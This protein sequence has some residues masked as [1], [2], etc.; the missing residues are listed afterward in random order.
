MS[1]EV[2]DVA[3]TLDASSTLTGRPSSTHYHVVVV[4]DGLPVAACN[5]SAITNYDGP[6]EANLLQRPCWFPGIPLGKVHRHLRCRRSGC[7]QRWPS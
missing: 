3:A 1:T 5:R 7:A 2:L 6:R 4:V